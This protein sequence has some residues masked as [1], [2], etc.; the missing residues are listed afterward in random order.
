MFRRTHTCGELRASHN[1]EEVALNGWVA[2]K[3]DH[4]G[5]IFIDLRDRYGLTQLTFNEETF[6]D[7]FKVARK[8]SMEDVLSVRGKVSMRK[9]GAINRDI[10]TGEIELGINVVE[11]L[12]EAAP[13]PFLVSDRDSASEELRLIYR[14]LDLRTEELQKFMA[15]RHKTYQAV[16]NH[17]SSENFMEVETPFLM[18]SS[19]EGARDY[20]VPSRIHR[21]KFYALPQSPQTY[22]QLLMIAGFDRYF[23]IVKCFRDEDLRADRQPEFTQ[24]DLEMSFVDEKDVREVVEKLVKHVFKEIRQIEIE[25]PFPKISHGDAIETYGTDSP[26]LRFDLH[27]LD[28][29]KWA[30][31]STFDTLSAP[32]HSTC[33]VIDE[34]E[35]YSRKAVDQFTDFAMEYSAQEGKKTVWG[36]GWMRYRDGDLAGGLSKSFPGK[37]RRELASELKLN[38]GSLLLVTGGERETVLATM[39]ALRLQIAKRGNMIDDSVFKPSW[40]VEFPL[41]ER[42]EKGGDWTFLHHPFTAPKLEHVAMLEADPAAVRSRGYDLVI[43]GL[44]VAGGSIRNHDP[45]IQLRIF[46][47]LGM[48]ETEARR[49]FG[50]LLEALSYGAPPHGGI[51]FGFDRFVMLLAGA[52]QIRDVIAF[53]KTTSALSLMDG[54]PSEIREEQLGELGIQILD[55]ED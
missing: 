16:R 4:G 21:G 20:V 34:G 46:K 49:R 29:S 25:T 52:G 26:D 37:L 18:K 47:L 23:Q 51:A 14:Y 38:E 5:V 13:L 11:V 24:I 55:K 32:E 3:R 53:P 40:V 7:A 28:F 2:S 54:S 43:N 39:G 44:E 42:D 36:L 33:I 9:E 19:P 48:P 50:F 12:S 15:I 27:L 10:A 41:L 45:D 35:A 6:P 30:A 17:L 31:K 8:L 22:K 1:G